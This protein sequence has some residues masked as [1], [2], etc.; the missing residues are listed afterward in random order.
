[1]SL[2]KMKSEGGSASAVFAIPPYVTAST[3]RVRT[4]ARRHY[5]EQY[6]P[7]LPSSDKSLHISAVSFP[8]TQLSASLISPSFPIHSLIFDRVLFSRERNSS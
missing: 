1:M 8:P 6:A 7:S 2:R 3:A 4:P 5:Q